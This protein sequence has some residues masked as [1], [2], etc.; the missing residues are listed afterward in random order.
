MNR[1]HYPS[2]LIA[3]AIASTIGAAQAQSSTGA[4]PGGAATRTQVRMETKEFLKTHRWDE[5][6]ETWMLKN[7]VEP[8]VGVI[9]RAVFRSQRDDFLRKNSWNDM[10]STWVP[11]DPVPATLSNLTRAQQ[12]ADTLAFMRT[13]SWDEEGGE[14]VVNPSRQM[15]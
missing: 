4:S 15:K 8:P 10:N 9:P 6:T 13:H 3:L 12:Q 11:R 2:L 1:I 7:G 14:W 5:I